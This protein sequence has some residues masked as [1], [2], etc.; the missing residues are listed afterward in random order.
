MSA[1]VDDILEIIGERRLKPRGSLALSDARE[2]LVHRS[3]RGAFGPDGQ[4][5]P[6]TLRP[7]LL[8]DTSLPKDAQEYLPESIFEGDLDSDLASLCDEE[9]VWA[10]FLEGHYGHFLTGCISRLWPLLPGA[11]LEGL[12]VV[13]TSPGEWPFAR[14]WLDAFGVRMVTLPERGLARFKRMYIPEPVFR[15]RVWL[16]REIRDIHLHARRGM[17]VSTDRRSDVLWLSRSNLGFNRRAAYDECLLEWL[18]REHVEVVNPETMTLA[19]Q[20]G[21]LEASQAVAGVIGSAFYGLFMADEPPPYACLCPPKIVSPFLAQADLLEVDATFRYSLE[22]TSRAFGG[23]RGK[24]RLLYRVLIP[25]SLRALGA[26][27]LP[28]LR[29]DPRVA[30]LADPGRRCPVTLPGSSDGHAEKAVAEMLREPLSGEARMKL[31]RALEGEGLNRCAFEQYAAVVGLGGDA[32]SRALGAAGRLAGVGGVGEASPMVRRVLS[33]DP[34]FREA[35]EG[36]AEQPP[37]GGTAFI[38]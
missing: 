29:E 10:G 25:R 17:G 4:L 35:M 3:V 21:A 1:S 5:V 30:N 28:A 38:D 9:V 15:P 16:G 33:V 14:E 20:I 24:P 18:L 2:L 6:S 8:A 34:G 37:S 13:F 22:F 26:S 31:A 12:P 36:L 19:E 23:G 11:R 32:A 7:R 27:V